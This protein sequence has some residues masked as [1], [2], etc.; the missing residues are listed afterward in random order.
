M[1]VNV[2]P[3]L[4]R[5]PSISLSMFRGSVAT[6]Q[7]AEPSINRESLEAFPSLESQTHDLEGFGLCVILSRDLHLSINLYLLRQPVIG[8]HFGLL[9][10]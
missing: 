8:A 1:V 6:L 10:R 5:L 7:F 4:I 3:R 2:S 9:P